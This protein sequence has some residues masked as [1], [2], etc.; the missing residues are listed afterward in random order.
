MA[1]FLLGTPG[2]RGAE[3]QVSLRAELRDL[4]WALQTPGCAPEHKTPEP[5][6]MQAGNE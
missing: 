2:T 4:S 5:Q 1:E 6:G 3:P